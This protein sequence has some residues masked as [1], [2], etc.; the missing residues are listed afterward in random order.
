[1]QQV[2]ELVHTVAKTDATVLIRGESGTGKELIARAIHANSSRRYMPIVTVNCGALAEGVL[3]SEL[4]GHE[5]GRSRGRTTN[6]RASSRWQTGGRSSWTKSGT[7]ASRRRP[8][9]LG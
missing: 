2:M 7:S 5:K 1:M 4:F 3:E 8:T 9:S 6:E